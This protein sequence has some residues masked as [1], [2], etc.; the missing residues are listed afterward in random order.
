MMFSEMEGSGREEGAR[1]QE[2][3]RFTFREAVEE[4]LF[5]TL[6]GNKGI[7]DGKGSEDTL[8]KAEAKAK[9]KSGAD[10]LMRH[11]VNEFEGNVKTPSGGSDLLKK[12]GHF[13]DGIK[14]RG[15]RGGG[16]QGGI[17][18]VDERA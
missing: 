13:R 15:G 3:R 16:K 14:A 12:S 7:T 8:P 11:G 18:D 2:G 17:P 5:P 4:G 1:V 10:A 6:R 9:A